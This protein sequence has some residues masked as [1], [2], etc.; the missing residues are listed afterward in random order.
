[1]P[2]Y[3]FLCMDCGQ[4]SEVLI[5]NSDSTPECHACGSQN[6]KKLLSAHSSMSGP[7]KNTM[8]GQGDTTCCG[9][10]PGTNCAGPGSCCGKN[11]GL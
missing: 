11:I 8:P 2:L 3:D 7:N 9:S 10:S 6:M 5:I 4:Q 1:M